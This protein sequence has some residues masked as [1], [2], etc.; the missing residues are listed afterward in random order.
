MLPLTLA[1]ITRDEEERI[2]R[3]IESVGDV[4]EVL[5]LDSGSTDKT[6]SIAE[7]LGARVIQTDWPG[8]GAQK[9]RALEMAAQDWVLSIDADEAVSAELR[10]AL[11]QLFKTEPTCSAYAVRRQNHWKGHRIRFGTYGPQWKTRLVRKGAAVWEGGILHE[12]L[13][14]KNS[15]GRLRGVLEHWPYKDEADFQETSQNYAT[16]FAEKSLSEGRRSRWWDR[17]L[18]P[19]LHFVKSALLKGGFLEGKR[20]FRLASLGAKEVAM[21]WSRLAVLERETAD[22]ERLP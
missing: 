22:S 17:H 9:N 8:Y 5:V 11:E 19:I 12:T 10:A 15:V 1:I 3:A 13:V 18:R 2:S 7:S 21:K 16:L 4:A 20:G 14:A 6:V